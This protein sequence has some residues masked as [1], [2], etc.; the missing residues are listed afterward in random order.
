MISSIHKEHNNGCNS[1]K[2]RTIPEILFP[3]K[4]AI[5]PPMITTIA[6]ITPKT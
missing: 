5:K 3:K 4:I 6:I 2:N 1:N